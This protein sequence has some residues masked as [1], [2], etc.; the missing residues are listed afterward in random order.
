MI[1][2]L[3][4]A[5]RRS[6]LISYRINSLTHLLPKTPN[7]LFHRSPLPSF[8]LILFHLSTQKHLRLSGTWGPPKHWRLEMN[9]ILNQ[10]TRQAQANSLGLVYMI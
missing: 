9:E 1:V 6:P 3:T 5:W 2:K 10:M 4:S 8:L 7:V